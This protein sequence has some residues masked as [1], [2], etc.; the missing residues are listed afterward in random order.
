MKDLHGRSGRVA[1]AAKKRD[2]A[3]PERPAL[4]T[5]AVEAPARREVRVNE[6]RRAIVAMMLACG[7]DYRESLGV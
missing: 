6:E 1:F 4:L 2:P 5:R 7:R 3:M